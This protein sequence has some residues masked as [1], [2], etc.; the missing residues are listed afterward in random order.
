MIYY[1]YFQ[2]N[3]MSPSTQSANYH[4]CLPRVVV[5]TPRVMKTLKKV[6]NK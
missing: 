5:V 4:I 1:L 3:Q 2:L 6:I